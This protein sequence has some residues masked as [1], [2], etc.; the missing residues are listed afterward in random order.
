MATANL[1][2]PPSGY[3]LD[4]PQQ[5]ASGSTNLP[6]PPSG[7]T[8]DQ[9]GA[10]QGG[11]DGGY[12]HQ[13]AHNLVPSAWN[14]I[15]SMAPGPA[16]S[17]WSPE[18]TAWFQQAAQ[19]EKAGKPLP[20]APTPSG[21]FSQ[22]HPDFA[23]QHPTLATAA[24]SIEALASKLSHPAD[25]FRDDPVGAL[26]TYG[27]LARGGFDTAKATASALSEPAQNLA[28]KLYQGALKPS[29]ANPAKAARAVQT[30]L[31][32]GIP[33]SESGQAK[34]GSL[35]DDLAEKTKDII[36]SNPE[37]TI[38]PNAVAARAA[39]TEGRF[40]NQVNP[41]SDVSAVRNSVQEFLDNAGATPAKAPQ[42]TG[43]VDQYGNPIVAPGS[44]AQPAPPMSA[45]DAQA[46][47][48]GTYQQ[49]KDKSYG[50]MKT[51]QTESEKALARGLK[52]ELENQFPELKATNAKSSDFYNLQPFIQKAVGRIGNWNIVRLGDYLSAAGAAGSAA[53]HGGET[54]LITAG[55][56][57][58][59]NHVLMDPAFQSRLAIALN[60][61]AKAA[62]RTESVASTAQRIGEYGQ[63][64]RAAATPGQFAHGINAPATPAALPLAA[65]NDQTPSQQL[66]Q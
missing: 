62:G 27:N 52:E 37:A 22:A 32:A 55:T 31:N 1:P 65:Q 47:K 41:K 11:A 38:D 3:T 48:Q 28:Q 57:A 14:F 40:A 54:G 50:D 66:G 15:K 17:E 46:M 30:G 4:S 2:P 19:A 12:W 23:Q 39:Q 5:A 43:L 13:V 42:A 20:Q 64:L 8:L 34:L 51:A 9:P 18:Q 44:P 56:A 25:Y 26:N 59:L 21:S 6:P 35:I 49:L 29:Q 33:I 61:A 24:D 63:A 36:A 53:L 60:V 7:Y 16:S 58:L 45:A 10:N